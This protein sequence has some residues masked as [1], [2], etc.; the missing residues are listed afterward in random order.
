MSTLKLGDGRALNG[1]LAGRKA[2]ILCDCESLGLSIV[3]NAMKYGAGSNL[4]NLYSGPRCKHGHPVDTINAVSQLQVY[5]GEDVKVYGRA[6][7]N[8]WLGITMKNSVALVYFVSR[9]R[10]AKD[11]VSAFDLYLVDKLW[12]NSGVV[13]YADEMWVWVLPGYQAPKAH[14][15]HH[16]HKSHKS[17]I[18]IF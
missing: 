13:D 1:Y 5:Y 11:K 2:E 8:A 17:H 3:L 16:H 18:R 6:D 15:R 14:H 9:G 4:I 7:I 10:R 12:I